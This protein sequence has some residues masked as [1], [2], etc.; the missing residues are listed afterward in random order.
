MYGERRRSRSDSLLLYG[1]EYL[2]LHPFLFIED[3]LLPLNGREEL[4]LHLCSFIEDVLLPLNGREYLLLHLCPFIEDDLVSYCLWS[5]FNTTLRPP[6]P[7]SPSM[8]GEGRRSRSDS[9]FLYD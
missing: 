7:S 3:V 1:Q 9:P 5:R 2:L 6:A 4:L 8:Y